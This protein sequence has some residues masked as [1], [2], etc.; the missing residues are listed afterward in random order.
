MVK[1][2]GIFV[3]PA[4]HATI[5]VLLFATTTTLVIVV[6]IS[7]SSISGGLAQYGSVSP[8]YIQKIP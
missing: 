4:G 2:D 5:V 7:S 6:V 1:W 3:S 8:E